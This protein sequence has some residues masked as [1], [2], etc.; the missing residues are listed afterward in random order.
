MAVSRAQAI[1][2]RFFRELW[3]RILFVAPAILILAAGFFL[4]YQFVR[5][6]PPSRVVMAT[7]AEDGA[8]HA[9][10][11][12]Y[13]E[14]FRKE[15][16]ELVLKTTAGS[17]ENLAL[18]DDE[19]AEVPVAFLQGGIG[20]PEDHPKLTSLGSLYFEPIWVFVRTDTTPRRLT[21]LLG[22]RISIGPEGSGSRA[23]ALPLLEANGI[24][25]ETAQLLDLDIS[26]S[27]KALESGTIDAAII[28]GAAS[29]RT[30]RTVLGMP[31]VLPMSFERAD[32]YVRR[33]HYLSKVVLPMGTVDLAKN[34]PKED[35]VLL[36]PTAAV[37][38]SPEMHPALI[39]LMLLTMKDVH[40]AGGYLEKPGEFP[41]SLHVTYPLE[42]AAKRFYERGPPFLQRYLPFSI[43][44]LIDRL[45]V[46]ILPLLTLLYPLFK[47]L[48]PIYNWRMQSRVN[49]W[50]KELAALDDQ[51][52]AGSVSKAEA[53]ERLDKIEHSV[54]QVSV[55]TGFAASAY[56]LRMHID[57]L[58]HKVD[59]RAKQDTPIAAAG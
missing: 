17:V 27:V 26:D 33:Y 1:S 46:M 59:G 2:R 19:K 6:A 31:G 48:P 44:N 13:A 45:K 20:R 9:F 43:A 53:H 12:I 55:P 35:V 41:S 21:E 58:R 28:V 22:K 11:K 40:G 32:A 38:V 16:F 49:R 30:I 29:S 51:L 3:S 47:L 36:A 4:A 39:D 7:G 5:P 25:A 37:V 15:G 56:T 24:T 57:Y 34:L 14:R 54:E 18:L 52:T 10:G 8:Y 50:Y 23:V 42:P